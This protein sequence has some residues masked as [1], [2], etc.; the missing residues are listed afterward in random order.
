MPVIGTLAGSLVWGLVWYPFRVLDEAGV[1]GAQATLITYLLAMIFAMFMLPRVWRELP[2]VGWWAVLLVLSVG[3]TNLSYVL[4]ILHGEVMRVLL[5]FYL[6]PLWTILFSYWLLGE[7][8]NGYGYLVISLSFTGAVIML[9]EP[10]LGLPLPQNVAEW[11]ALSS[12]AAFAFSNVVSRR[13]AHMSVEAKSYGVWFGTALL[14]GPLVWW[15]GG[16]VTQLAAIDAYE[17]VML[18]IIGLVMC[19]TGF[20]VQYAIAGLPANRAIV[21]FMFELVV[22]AI[23]SYFLAGEAMG[24]REWSSALLIVSAS[25]LSG[26]LHGEE[27][28]V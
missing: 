13:A 17:W 5:L 15:Q 14:T 27:S 7:R 25:L 16:L 23:A 26:K 9:W 18:T 12:G 20:A 3:W 11:I 8:L 28:V 21:L 6:A 22:A 1:S 19:G 24:L 2:K 4:A 10:S